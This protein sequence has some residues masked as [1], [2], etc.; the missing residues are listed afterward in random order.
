MP[1][2]DGTGPN[3][4]GPKTGGGKGRCGKKAGNNDG[5]SSK[6]R[7]GRKSCSQQD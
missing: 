5:G 4:E 1:N 3:G 7:C 6:G 2:K